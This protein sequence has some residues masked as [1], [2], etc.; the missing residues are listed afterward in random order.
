MP[1]LLLPLTFLLHSKLL[2][3]KQSKFFFLA[4]FLAAFSA[5]QNRVGD[6]HSEPKLLSWFSIN[7][8]TDTLHFEVKPE[9]GDSL[10]NIIPNSVLFFSIDTALQRKFEQVLDTSEMV[11]A[12]K[13]RVVLNEDFDACLLDIHQF[14]FRYKMLLLFDK[15]HNSFTDLVTVAEWYGGDG[16]Q[17]L[18]GSWLFDYD[19]D[20]QKDLVLRQIEH[21]MHV[22]E[23]G[24]PQESNTENASLLLW[25]NGKFAASTADTANLIKRFPIASPF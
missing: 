17:I 6:A 23:D 13:D 16:G 20:G 19:G 9:A 18:T 3:L 8:T 5:C 12:G 2:P 10:T 14:W 7:P 24:E 21:S 1:L 15:K 11:V 4:T 22:T 25:K